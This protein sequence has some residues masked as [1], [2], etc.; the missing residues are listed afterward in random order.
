MPFADFHIHG[1]FKSYFTGNEIKDKKSP[2]E[3]IIYKVDKIMFRRYNEIFSSQSC[4][5]QI[6]RGD[7]QLAVV[8]L[9]SVEHGFVGSF[10]LKALNFFSKNIDNSLYREILKGKV[11][12]YE[13]L[14][15]CLNHLK[16]AA[17]ASHPQAHLVNFTRTFSDIK[18]N[19]INVIYSLEGAHAFLD[20]DADVATPQGMEQAMTR[21]NDFKKKAPNAEFPRIFIL[22]FTHLTRAP[23]GNHAFGIKMISHVDF[24]PEGRGI[25]LAGWKL[26]E[27]ALAS[28]TDHYPMLI[29]IKHM[30]LE[31]RKAYYAFRA[32]RYPHIP[33]VASHVGCTGIS[34]E[35][36]NDYILEINA[37]QFN[38]KRCNL[39]EYRKPDGHL[40]DTGFNP[41]SIN[42][43]DE[44]IAEILAS[45]GIIG[46]SLD[47]R[48]LGTGKLAR[49]KMSRAETFEGITPLRPAL[50]ADPEEEPSI[51]DAELHFR[52]FCNNLFHIIKVGQ[53]IENFG[54]EGWKRVVIGSDFDGL[55]DAVDFCPTAEDFK[56]I[57]TYMREK[58]PALAS[59]ARI[60]LPG[61]LQ[62]LIDGIL[63]TN[64]YEFLKKYY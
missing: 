11:T 7:V 10:L 42:L 58:L 21:V 40:Q 18:P 29:D 64:G 39:V 17:T 55:I 34:Y 37:P 15:D 45:G 44:D 1:N 46:L 57:A 61:E 23:F 27:T 31:C 33:I 47:Q 8:P 14:V 56:G 35:Q 22:N 51:K 52:H 50:A 5:S 9:Y 59:E 54:D 4:F 19:H 32:E 3:R 2:W 28:D 16:T 26:I 63:Y 53:R 13:Q 6:L 43:Y 38:K 62:K 20:R 30:S 49:E 36:V 12:H 48:I 24:I 60:A 41:W 25:S